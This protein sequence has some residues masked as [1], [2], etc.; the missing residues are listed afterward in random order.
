MVGRVAAKSTSQANEGEVKLRFGGGINTRASTDEV[1]DRECVSGS[2]NFDLD[3]GNTQ[4]RPRLQIDLAGTV[5][6]AGQIN[7]YAQLVDS[8]G[9]ITTLIQGAGNI[10]STT[11]FSTWT[12]VEAVS[13]T[14]RIRGPRSHIWNLTDVVLIT[15]IA[16]VNPLM[17]WNGTYLDTVAHNLAGT[18]IAKYCHVDNERAFFGNVISNGT[19]TPHVIVGSAQSDYTTLSTSQKP[20]SAISD[21]DAFYLLTPDLKPINGIAGAFGV[22]AVS[23]KRGLMFKLNGSSA[24]DFGF[25]ALYYDSYADGNESMVFAGNDIVYGRPGR[26]ESLIGTANYGDVET[27]DL[28]VKISDSIATYNGWTLAYSSRHQRIYCFAANTAELWVFHK[29]LADSG[30]SPWMK[31]KTAHAFGF[32]ITC[33]WSMLDPSSGLEHV[34][35]GD[36]S[37]RIFRLEGTGSGG[38]GGTASIT[39]VRTSKLISAPGQAQFYDV[40]GAVRYRPVTGATDNSLTLSIY[41]QGESVFDTSAEVPI[42]GQ[43][44]GAVYGGAYYYSDGTVYGSAFEGRLTRSKFAIA[45]Q[46]ND[47]QCNLAISGT[48]SFQ[49]NEVYMGL[50]ASG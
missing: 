35:C 41:F 20:S 2:Q 49:I 11:D 3:L 32:G 15:D 44:A 1:D 28:S 38:D 10:Y 17:V 19:S 23:T 24:Q 7:G 12:Y 29:P 6:N 46:G 45:G 30:L 39:A 26:I 14:A 50:K 8:S 25:D 48:N 47:I 4:F 16:G 34:F 18:F 5:P 9:N 43:E 33:M 36:S 22:L 13:T 42:S 21:S 27:D 37:G 31:W 40:Q